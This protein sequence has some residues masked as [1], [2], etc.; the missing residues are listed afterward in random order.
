MSARIGIRDFRHKLASVLD[1]AER[2][3]V[4][5][6]TRHGRAVAVVGPARGA[7]S[8]LSREVNDCVQAL[9]EAE[10]QRDEALAEGARLRSAVDRLETELSDA[11]ELLSQRRRRGF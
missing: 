11:R 3:R 1:S 6:I 7:V 10:R 4:F 2:G 9:A 5:L 8:E